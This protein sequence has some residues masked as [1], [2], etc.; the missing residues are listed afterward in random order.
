MEDTNVIAWSRYVQEQAAPLISIVIP[1][2]NLATYLPRCLDSITQQKLGEIEIVA[3]DGGSQDASVDVLRE[4]SL[5]DPRLT[6][7]CAGRIGPGRAR[8]A[9]A[10]IA[11]GDYLWFVDGDD[12]ISADC[13]TAI[14]DK[15]EVTRPDVL[16]L[17]HQV[18][19]PDGRVEPGAGHAMLARDT[20]ACF[21]L[22][23]QPWVTKLSM[24]SW[25]KVIRREFFLTRPVLFLPHS[26]RAGG[27]IAP[28]DRRRYFNEMHAHFIRYLPPDY[29][30]PGGFRGI[31]Y[32]LI[33]I[34][35]Y[36]AYSILDPV[37][38]LRVRAS[39]GGVS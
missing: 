20:E 33:K 10:E 32:W 4:R 15:L 26:L 36:R 9:G 27:F 22:A 1:I 12:L 19:W 21:T 23:G 8:N 18:A 24:A 31:K 13:L 30:Y 7:V 11:T 17:D 37:N 35:A 3:V 39:P 6:V 25:N 5:K 34:K 29:H 16:F 28:A 14:A 38:K 2:Y